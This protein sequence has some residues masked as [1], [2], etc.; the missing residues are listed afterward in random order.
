MSIEAKD[1]QAK[2]KEIVRYPGPLLITFDWVTRLVWDWLLYQTSGWFQS[3]AFRDE[4]PYI[5]RRDVLTLVSVLSSIGLFLTLPI[6]NSLLLK[7]GAL[8]IS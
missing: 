5:I 3:P 4:R 7:L 2:Q 6:K 1:K 8:A